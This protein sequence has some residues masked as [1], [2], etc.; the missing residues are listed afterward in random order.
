M[1]SVGMGLRAMGGEQGGG[2]QLGREGVDTFR[3]TY[4]GGSVAAVLC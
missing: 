4:G 2:R 3:S 1:Q